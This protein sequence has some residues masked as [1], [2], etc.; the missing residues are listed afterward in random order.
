MRPVSLAL[1]ALVTTG[2]LL[3]APVL[4]GDAAAQGE[5][6]TLLNPDMV[7]LDIVEDLATFEWV[8]DVRN[9]TDEPLRLRI[10]LDLL[11]DDD[12]PVNRDE[13]G[14]PQNAVII[15]VEP[16]QTM[17]VEQ[18]GGLSYDL[19]AEIVTFRHRWEIIQAPR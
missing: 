18:Q 5:A 13:Q 19:A 3:L 17:P 7:Y 2:V 12:R 9:N 11:D 16:Q 1:R 4:V 10:V 15:T 14:N 8:V 6:I